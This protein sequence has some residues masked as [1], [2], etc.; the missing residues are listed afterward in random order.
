MYY[1]MCEKFINLQISYKD[2]INSVPKHYLN[3]ITEQPINIT[4]SHLINL[5]CAYQNN[6]ISKDELIKWVNVVWFNDV[7][8]YDETCCDCIATIL[9]E[10]EQLDEPTK[11][12]DKKIINDY[13]VM[14]KNREL[15]F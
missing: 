4:C 2:L 14:L 3:S 8:D 5:L 15:L 13:V 7:F 9:T 12:L 11:E 10:L 6:S 1:L